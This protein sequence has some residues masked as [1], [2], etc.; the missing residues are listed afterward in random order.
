MGMGQ[1]DDGSFADAESVSGVEDK[2]P[3]SE[4]EEDET[5]KGCALPHI[6]TGRCTGI[7]LAVYVTTLSQSSFCHGGGG[8]GDDGDGVHLIHLSMGCCASTYTPLSLSLFLSLSTSS[9]PHYSCEATDGCMYCLVTFL[10]IYF[11]K[12][13]GCVSLL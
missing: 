10:L 4:E 7:Y 8:G 9:T 3:F 5:D 12:M 11:L 6:P 1:H 2:G 13:F